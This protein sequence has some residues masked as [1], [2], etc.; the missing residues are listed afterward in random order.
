MPALPAAAALITIRSLLAIR[1]TYTASNQVRIG[2]TAVSS[3]GGYSEFANI[4]DIRFKKNIQPATH[5]L[6]FM[7]QLQP[8]TYNLDIT[9]LNH[10]IYGEA[11]DTLFNAEDKQAM[12]AKEETLT[13]GISAQQVESVAKAI[14]YEFS[15]VEKP[16]SDK[17]HYAI[18]YATFVVPLVKAVQ[19]Q[20]QMIDTQKM[21]IK[22]LEKRLDKME[23]GKKEQAKLITQQKLRYT[24]K[25]AHE[26][27]CSRAFFSFSGAAGSRTLVQT[28][29]PY[30][31]YM[32]I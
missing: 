11:A 2:N 19:E 28:N 17:D 8:I 15:G 7:L 5:G 10:F 3:I 27:H 30:A 24:P 21:L 4:S 32:L 29:P 23:E 13:T 6:D 25:K 26:H 16:Q 9:K 12:A 20:Q 1:L 14:G 18:A 22:K 31:F